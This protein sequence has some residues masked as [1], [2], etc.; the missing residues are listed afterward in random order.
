MARGIGRRTR[1][2]ADMTP[3]PQWSPT[4]EM[5]RGRPVFTETLY[6][7]K[8]VRIG[9]DRNG[10]PRYMDVEDKEKP[11]VREFV[12]H[13]VGNGQVYKNYDFRGPDPSTQP[14]RVSEM[15]ALRAEYESL[16]RV[17]ANMVGRKKGV[18]FASKTTD[19]PDEGEAGEEG[20]D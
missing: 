15:D 18:P 20:K 16:K 11:I 6:E 3:D 4:G 2:N 10:N 1:I 9:D 8:R 7:L 12:Q 5:Y 14:P 17:V 13:D 19:D